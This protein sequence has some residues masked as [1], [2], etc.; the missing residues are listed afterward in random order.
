M[1]VAELI[2]VLKTMPQKA[3]VDYET[4]TSYV[5]IVKNR[6]YTIEVQDPSRVKET[7]VVLS[8]VIYRV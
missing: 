7:R 1:T 3:Q 6:I 8:G 5:P 4:D 2:E